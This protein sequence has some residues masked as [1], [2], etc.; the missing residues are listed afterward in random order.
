MA[1]RNES[2]IIRRALAAAAPILDGACI[3]DTGSN[4]GTPDIARDWLTAHKIPFR[5]VS[6]PWTDFGI[7]R[8]AALQEA[9]Q[10]ADQEEWPRAH[11]Y[12]LLLDADHELMID[13]AFDRTALHAPAFSL[14]QRTRHLEYWNLRLARAD[15]AWSAV[16]RTHERY[17]A[18]ELPAFEPLH[19]LSIRDHGDG[20]SKT[21]KF[22]RDIEWLSATLADTPDDPRTLFYLAQS[23]RA[24]NEPLK[25]L[26]LYRRR[27]AIDDGHSEV[28]Y[29][30]L[31]IG[32]IL[33]EGGDFGL[34]VRALT[35]ARE[36]DRTRAEPLY[37]LARLYRRHGEFDKAMALADEGRTLPL[38]DR[39]FLVHADVYEQGLPLEFALAAARTPRAAAEFDACE[40]VSLGR[41]Q[42][43]TAVDAA[44]L[45]ETVYVSSLE[46]LRFLPIHPATEATYRPCNPS[47]TQTA[48]GYVMICRTVNYEQRRLNYRSLAPDQVYRT[49]NVLMRLATDFRVLDQHEITIEAP[50]IRE[51]RIRGL[52]DC[53]VVAASDGLMFTCCTTD[54]HPAGSV[55]QSICRLDSTGRVT[56]HQPLVGPF[57]GTP[58]KN[59]LPFIG[60]AGRLRA[61]H[62]YDPLT[63]LTIDPDSGVYSVEREVAQSVN[64]SHWRGSAGP[65]RWPG[66]RSPGW[67]VLV[68]EVVHRIG[69]DSGYERIYLHRFVEYD[70]SF[71]LTRLSRPFMFAHKGVEF[72]CGMTMTHDGNNLVLGLGMEDREAYMAR[73][74]VA[75][76]E[77]L[78]EARRP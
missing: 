2:T 73:I 58:Q 24:V 17:V 53:R 45:A 47:V 54:R 14:K 37:E 48:D 13:P 27:I 55:Q 15:V 50:P 68:H 43:A 49:R 60:D 52:E 4:D 69:A 6:H 19:T 22:T 23:Y 32:Q 78:L 67:L 40:R 51:T 30:K 38:P 8:S 25:A 39:G 10:F 16:G 64:G 7:N 1:V 76:V 26:L 74:D 36:A 59:W 70:D 56:S 75:R 28:W 46:G 3:C 66:G 65:L 63:V 21:D 29:S 57:D 11:A 12:W 42:P 72:A 61:I 9:A 62:S 44:R 41:D 31:G 18:P 5:I 35:E 20:G 33:A 71:T 34:A 77:G